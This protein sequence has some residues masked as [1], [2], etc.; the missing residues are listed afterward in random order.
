M[1]R[2]A[3]TSYMNHAAGFDD[4]KPIAKEGHNWYPPNTMLNTPV[5]ALDTLFIMGL[6]AEFR[7]AKKLV[8][9]LDFGSVTGRIS[10]FETTIRVLGGLLA[11]FELAGDV[12]FLN[13]AVELA[14]KLLP[15]FNQTENGLPL[16]YLDLRLGIAYDKQGHFETVT[17]AAVGTLQL[18]FQYLSDVTGNA[19]YAEKALFVYDQL[20]A[21]H[22]LIPGLF[23]E[24]LSTKT[25]DAP[26]T[27]FHIGA[28]A[29][30][31][32]EYLLKLWVSTNSSKYEAMYQTASQSIQKHLIKL[33]ADKSHIYIPVVNI[34][35]S[36]NGEFASLYGDD[37]EHLA[38]F[39]GGMFALGAMT[40]KSNNNNKS[41]KVDFEVG[42]NLTETCWQ[43]Y[44]HSPTGIGPDVVYAETFAPKHP[45]Y[46]LRP[47][48]VESLF[49][50]WRFTHDQKYRDRGWA[51]AQ[52][53][54][55]HCKSSAGYHGLLNVSN[56]TNPGTWDH[57][58]SFFLA[59]TLKYLFLLFSEDDVIPLTQ[60]V[61]NT[62]AH[63]L[64]IRG[65]GKRKDS[66]LWVSLPDEL[67]YSRTVGVLKEVSEDLKALRYGGVANKGG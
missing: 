52:A 40:A 37:F 30:S 2:H 22:A 11:A 64:S 16:N 36:A 58:E 5:D 13:K 35:K 3:W 43:M 54:E 6:D 45:V 33:S 18:E 14:D 9:R 60:N 61:F 44:A 46:K 4:L 63:A 28:R 39:S 57:Q 38:C 10:V 24:T 1:T 7:Q 62:E 48:V 8:Q 29:D 26:G 56:P 50:L 42:K 41:W 55:R 12:C 20:Q 15:V 51:L 66:S 21:M 67:T 32:Y 47:E 25:L 23:P 27:T 59:E 34:S 17:L 31:Y 19:T 49:Y 53:L 65:F